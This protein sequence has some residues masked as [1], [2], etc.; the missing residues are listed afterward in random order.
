MQPVLGICTARW[1]L[2]GCVPAECPPVSVSAACLTMLQ[3]KHD[4]A[5]MRRSGSVAGERSQGQQEKV[6]GREVG[7]REVGCSTHTK[8]GGLPGGGHGMPGASG[9]AQNDG[10]RLIWSITSADVR[11][12]RPAGQQQT[13]RVLFSGAWAGSHPPPCFWWRWGCAPPCHPGLCRQSFGSRGATCRAAGNG[14]GAGGRAGRAVECGGRR[15]E[16]ARERRNTD[17]EGAGRREGGKRKD[18]RGRGRVK[19]AWLG[20]GAVEG[21]RAPNPTAGRDVGAQ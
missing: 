3:P 7:C 6:G 5:G 11:A 21:A 12:G 8:L 13:H 20:K 18:E 14:S 19:V 2:C 9:G 10:G 16:R 1:L 15:S 17:G 4:Q